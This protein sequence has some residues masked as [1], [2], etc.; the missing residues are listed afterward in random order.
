MNGM[1]MATMNT[2]SMDLNDIAYDAYLANDRTLDRS[3]DRADGEGLTCAPADHQWRYGDWLY[4]R[5]GP[6]G[7]NAHRCRWHA[8]VQSEWQTV[9]LGYGTARGSPSSVAA[10]GRRISGAGA[11]R[12][13]AGAHGPDPRDARRREISQVSRTG[14][15]PGPVIGLD[16]EARL[17]AA[18]PLP[19]RS[20]DRR[21]MVHL[22]GTMM[23]Y[24]WGMKSEPIRVRQ[25]ERI[26]IR[27]AQHVD[28]VSSHAS[29]WSSLPG[30]G[31]QRQVSRA[32]CVT[33]CW[34][35][36]CRA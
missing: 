3:R 19:S 18:D 24:S 9:P 31:H 26:E 27:D 29:S 6:I 12:R 8:R 1:D 7:G 32:R 20:A 13:C 30:R 14:Q 33:R 23:G 17:R 35:R 5:P 2:A 11:A 25:G 10:R 15:T 22:T 36:R 16:L 28:D 4:H 21:F 34:C